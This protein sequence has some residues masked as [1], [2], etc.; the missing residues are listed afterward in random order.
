MKNFI[1]R[2]NLISLSG[3]LLL[4]LIWK[5]ASVLAELEQI[6]PSPGKTLLSTWQIL[7]DPALWPDILNTVLRGFAGFILSLLL[8]VSLGIPA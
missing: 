4:F 6:V 8:A 3:I 1:S 2:K 7:T 5:I